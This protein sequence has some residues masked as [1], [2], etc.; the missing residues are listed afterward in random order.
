MPPRA[1][2]KGY[3]KI[4]ELTCPVL[5]Y[6]AVSAS[7]RIAFHTLNRATGHRVSRQ[8][9]DPDTNKPVPREDQVKGYAVG[10]GEY[11]VLEPEEIAAA[12]PE[13]DKAL[14]ADTFV[15]CREIDEVYLDRPYF[16]A[17][18]DAVAAKAYALI[19]EALTSSKVVAL[20][21]TVLFRRVRTVLVRAH[22][23]GLIANLL[24]FDYEVR[25]QAEAFDAIP[26]LS[27]KDEMLKLAEHI[28][29]TKRG[30]FDP[31]AFDDRYENAVA[32]MVKAKLAGRPLAAKPAPKASN[33]V[34]LL[35]AL[36]ESAKMS[37]AAPAKKGGRAPK[38]GTV[39]AASSKTKA[40]RVEK[41]AVAP[42][43]RKAS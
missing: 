41:A 31:K 43:R 9:I 33:V 32:D 3:L 13:S 23:G 40:G 39:A 1:V 28:I 38:A 27:I 2:W 18:S 4:A 16:L 26:E 19:C 14:M 25:S 6:T 37:G 42:P 29:S 11:I 35:A 36:R 10:S 7:E 22:D 12:L 15:P 34:D 30:T 8:F 17:P 24:N 21:R 5:L 20:A